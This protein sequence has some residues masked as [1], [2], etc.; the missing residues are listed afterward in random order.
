MRKNKYVVLIAYT[1]FDSDTRAVGEVV[2]YTAK[3][4]RGYLRNGRIALQSD[5][6]QKNVVLKY[7]EDG[8]LAIYNVRTGAVLSKISTTLMTGNFDGTF[9]GQYTGDL[10]GNFYGVASGITVGGV[11][12]IAADTGIMVG[13]R[14][15]ILIN[16][17]AGAVNASV[18]DGTAG[19]EIVFKAIDVTNAATVTPL[20]LAD[21]ASIALATVRAYVRL[22]FD[23]TNWQIVGTG[24]TVNVT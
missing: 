9:N 2:E 14:K 1:D 11:Q 15:L 20:N 21:G 12:T 10:F 17:N 7:D 3:E 6:S 24:G 23:G 16:A 4:A 5:L 18:A 13:A 22:Q 19:Q 8:D